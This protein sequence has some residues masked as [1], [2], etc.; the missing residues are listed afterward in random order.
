MI[1]SIPFSPPPASPLMMCRLAEMPVLPI[2]SRFHFIV[3]EQKLR[4]L[5]PLVLV[6]ML[7]LLLLSM[8]SIKN[9]KEK[10]IET[11]EARL[12]LLLL[13]LPFLLLLPPHPQVL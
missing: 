5:L 2:G 3:V 12:H 10:K 7:L 9:R 1:I 4:S 8:F 11:G 13:L 6:Q